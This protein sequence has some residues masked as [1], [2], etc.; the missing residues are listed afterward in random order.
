MLM[1]TVAYAASLVLVAPVAIHPAGR[2]SFTGARPSASMRMRDSSPVQMTNI[3]SSSVLCRAIEVFEAQ[4]PGAEVVIFHQRDKAD[5]PRLGELL[6]AHN[7]GETEFAKD[8]GKL[9]HARVF[10]L[11]SCF[12]RGLLV[13]ASGEAK[14]AAGDGF[15]LRFP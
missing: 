8:D 5:G 12:G 15:I 3:A 7:G 13:L 2:G 4:P 11:R 10:R 14:L 6:L 1:K 9:H